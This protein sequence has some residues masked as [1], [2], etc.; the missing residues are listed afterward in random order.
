MD[1]FFWLFP[2]VQSLKEL[3]IREEA[4]G[5]CLT[6]L[7]L[8]VFATH[9]PTLVFISLPRFVIQHPHSWV[10]FIPTLR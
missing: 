2:R 9:N 4:K 1:K 3:V 10:A 8:L 7:E 6:P 5:S